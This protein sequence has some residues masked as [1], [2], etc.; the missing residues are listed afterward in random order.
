MDSSTTK[1][2]DSESPSRKEMSALRRFFTNTFARR[3]RRGNRGKTPGASSIFNATEDPAVVD[4]DSK[5]GDGDTPVANTESFFHE[6]SAPHG[7]LWRY[8]PHPATQLAQAIA[9][10]AN[11]NEGCLTPKKLTD[12]TPS[13]EKSESSAL[14][15]GSQG[16]LSTVLSLQLAAKEASDCYNDFMV[17]YASG[18]YN[19]SVNL[20]KPLGLPADLKFFVPPKPIDEGTRL[21]EV[22]RYR[23]AFTRQSVKAIERLIVA[24]RSLFKV[25]CATVSVMLEDR[26]LIICGAGMKRIREIPRAQSLEGHTLLSSFPVVIS[27]TAD[28]WRFANHPLVKEFPHI[29][30]WASAPLISPSGHVI[31][32]FSVFSHMARPDFDAS[33]CRRLQEFSESTVRLLD[34]E[35]ESRKNDS[36]SEVFDSLLHYPNDSSD[37][38]SAEEFDFPTPKEQDAFLSY[39][40]I[41]SSSLQLSRSVSKST[42]R[43]FRYKSKT[44]MTNVFH[45]FAEIIA[46]SLGYDTIVLVEVRKPEDTDGAAGAAQPKN[47]ILV[48]SAYGIDLNTAQLQLPTR[49]LALEALNS[50]C[51]IYSHSLFVSS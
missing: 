26:Q 47:E 15:A 36:K 44:N 18:F 40:D 17:N 13:V 10:Q 14:A 28:D 34:D 9:T 38:Y 35:L 12:T 5:H 30:F 31:G 41:Q 8:T 16:G 21:A 27:S 25:K 20:P 4:E 29:G 46:L 6:D 48:L 49:E 19:F 22:K 43:G 42:G 51:G 50:E 24:A 37:M 3:R 11:I 45:L 23:V 2:R 33:N 32:A 39:R 7:S 1:K